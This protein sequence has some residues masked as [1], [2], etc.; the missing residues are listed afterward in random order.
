[1]LLEDALELDALEDPVEQREGPD[2][3]GA[4]FQ[5]IG[6]GG[7]PRDNIPAGTAW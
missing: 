2:V 7:R 3:V 6:L 4:E 1:M 5:P